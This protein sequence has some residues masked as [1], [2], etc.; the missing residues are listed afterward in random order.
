M[1]GFVLRGVEPLVPSLRRCATALVCSF[2]VGLA[3][4]APAQRFTLLEGEAVVLSLIH[5]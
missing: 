1:F 2:A 3:A 4:A 5:I